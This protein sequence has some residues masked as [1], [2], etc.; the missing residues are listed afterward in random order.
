MHLKADPKSSY[1]DDRFILHLR[2]M[3]EVIPG[4][5]KITEIKG[6]YKTSRKTVER[7]R[8]R[9]REMGDSQVYRMFKLRAKD[10]EIFVE[11]TLD[12]VHQL[13]NEG[14]IPEWFVSRIWLDKEFGRRGEKGSPESDNRSTLTRDD[15]QRLVTTVETRYEAHISDLKEQLAAAQRREELAMQYAQQDK[16]LFAKAAESL[17]KVLA[18]PAIA[19]ATKATQATPHDV[20]TVND[21]ERGTRP[22]ENNS[23]PTNS[24][25]PGFWKR[26]ISRRKQADDAND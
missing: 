22:T 8:D 23:S 13:R 15:V 12:Q 17:T 10:G 1:C 24:G 18:L 2:A 7:R 21:R 5:V 20:I 19:E 14:R 16:Q 25:A 9:A 11:P 26:L 4:F 3:S 6:E